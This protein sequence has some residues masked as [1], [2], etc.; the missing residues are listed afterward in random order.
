LPK[1]T[2]GGGTMLTLDVQMGPWPSTCEIARVA[3]LAGAR[4]DLSALDEP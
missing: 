2:R 4:E 1:P 3:G